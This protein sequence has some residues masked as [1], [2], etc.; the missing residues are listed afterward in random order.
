MTTPRI[1]RLP[2]VLKLT[3]MGRS[4]ILAQVKKGQFPAPFKI[5]P[6]ARA[7]GWKSEHV[8]AWIASRG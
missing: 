2:E 3:G 1:L 6:G 4:F 7:V 8:E 5:A